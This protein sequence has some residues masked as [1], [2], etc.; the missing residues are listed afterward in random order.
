MESRQHL[1]LIGNP[2]DTAVE[3]HRG[4]IISFGEE[5]VTLDVEVV[6][7]NVWFTAEGDP[8]DLVFRAGQHGSL[9]GRHVVAEA[10]SD[11]VIKVA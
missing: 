7:G 11:S 10:L 8:N 4:A 9:T 2:G 3:L 5:H 1:T 6:S